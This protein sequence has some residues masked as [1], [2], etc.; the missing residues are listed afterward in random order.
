M[1]VT[2]FS[3]DILYTITRFLSTNDKIAMKETC[4][5][6]KNSIRFMEIKIEIMNVKF[7][8]LINGRIMWFK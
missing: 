4:L 2:M 5:D 7:D 3:N 6:F 1:N 8:K